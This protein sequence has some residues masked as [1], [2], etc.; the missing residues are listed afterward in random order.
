MSRDDELYLNWL[1]NKLAGVEEELLGLKA[2]E[3]EIRR[4]LTDKKQVMEAM[5]VTL[6]ALSPA[7]ERGLFFLSPTSSYVERGR[8]NVPS[9]IGHLLAKSGKVDINLHPKGG[10]VRPTV[11]GVIR[12]YETRG[13]LP[14]IH[15]GSEFRDYARSLDK[16]ER[17]QV[18]VLGPRLIDMHVVPEDELV[19]VQAHG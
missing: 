18:D 1:R 16:A 9:S 17:I 12:R 19:G 2:R 4:E 13:G 8:F 3:A 6:T 11:I 10:G 15:V 5:Q 14:V 7:S